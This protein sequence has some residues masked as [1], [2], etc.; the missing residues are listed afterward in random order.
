MNR[1]DDL[2]AQALYTEAI[3]T[4]SALIHKFR[5]FETDYQQTLTS[6]Q[7]RHL[8]EDDPLIQNS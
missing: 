8:H 5:V 3:E 2:E 6:S 4:I 1:L 7:M